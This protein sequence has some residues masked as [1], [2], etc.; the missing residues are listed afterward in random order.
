[1][2]HLLLL[3][4]I[5]FLLE[6][7]KEP[8]VVPKDYIEIDYIGQHYYKCLLIYKNKSDLEIIKQG[9]TQRFDSVKQIIPV[10]RPLTKE[11]KMNKVNSSFD[12]VIANKKSYNKI[13]NFMQT[14]DHLFTSGITYEG[15]KIILRGK[16]YWISYKSEH[17][18][19][20]ELKKYLTIQD[21][22][23]YVIERI[24][25]IAQAAEWPCRNNIDR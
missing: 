23:E 22:D 18:F 20:E 16:I 15:Y 4:F 13:I 17:Q 7:Q 11:E 21:C 3:F 10:E 8:D 6:N 12:F 2:K 24:D 19:F 1:M 25:V 14:R 5:P 9:L